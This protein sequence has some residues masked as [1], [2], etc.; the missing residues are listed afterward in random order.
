[1][2]DK[3]MAGIL[4][5]LL[6]ILLTGCDKA[7]SHRTADF[8]PDGKLVALIVENTENEKSTSQ[9]SVRPADKKDSEAFAVYTA[10]E[11]TQIFDVFWKSDKLFMFESGE[12]WS[13]PNLSEFREKNKKAPIPQYEIRLLSIPS[14]F[15]K[16][17]WFAKQNVY[18]KETFPCWTE[19]IYKYTDENGRKRKEMLYFETETLQNTNISSSRNSD[20]IIFEPIRKDGSG[21]TGGLTLLNTKTG[22]KKDI[23]TG[24][25]VSNPTISDDGSKI[26]FLEFVEEKAPAAGSSGMPSGG[27]ESSE[28]QEPT[29]TIMKVA[30]LGSGAENEVIMI[31]GLTDERPVWSKDGKYLFIAGG[32]DIAYTVECDRAYAAAEYAK[33]SEAKKAQEKNKNKKSVEKEQPPDDH[34][35]LN[36]VDV[37]EAGKKGLCRTV[38]GLIPE[39]ERNSTKYVYKDKSFSW[40]TLHK[41]YYDMGIAVRLIDHAD[42]FS[43]NP[44]TEQILVHRMKSP[45]ND[46]SGLW[47][48]DY[49]GMEIREV[50]YDYV[51]KFEAVNKFGMAVGVASSSGGG[52]PVILDTTTD[53][54]R[55]LIGRK[56]DLLTLASFN[57]D[58]GRFDA[59]KDYFEK[60]V[61]MY[62]LPEETGYRLIMIATYRETKDYEKMMKL[63]RK[64]PVADLQ[65]YFNVSG[66]L[67]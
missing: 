64:V 12:K 44:E 32:S 39:K 37:E 46:K 27:D 60:Y 8:S 33:E 1:M 14:S 41:Y 20:R 16:I 35:I 67:Q 66:E 59:A 40:Y 9:I 4:P 52:V 34:K 24:R 51:N 10:P 2:P 63:T 3:K 6:L 21:I 30:D 57:F 48:V 54:E 61:S 56:Q 17:K 18:L 62:G 22:E 19:E 7:P 5:V 13:C 29:K 23:L 65:G 47:L 15:V 49:S 11:N 42:Y 43:I 53:E 45:V 58:N 50:K 26:S 31:G 36:A 38:R 55:P 28:E 25:T